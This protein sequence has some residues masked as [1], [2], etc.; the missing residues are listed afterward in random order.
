MSAPARRNPKLSTSELLAAQARLRE[1]KHYAEAVTNLQLCGYYP[2]DPEARSL[3]TATAKKWDAREE[4]RKLERE[5]QR[6]DRFTGPRLHTG[7][8]A[9]LPAVDFGAEAQDQVEEARTRLDLD[10]ASAIKMPYTSLDQAVGHGLLP[11]QFWVL[12]GDSGQ[13]KTTVVMSMA[14]LWLRAN[15]RLFIL[16]LEQ[17]ADT[18]RLYLAALATGYPVRSVLKNDW[19]ALPPLAKGEIEANLLW[20][21]DAGAPLLHLVREGRPT[22]R[23]IPQLYRRAADFGAEA[24]IIDHIHR[25]PTRDHNEYADLCATIVE[26]AKTYKIPALATAQNHRGTGPGAGDRLKAHLLPYVDRIQGGKVLEQ[27]ASVILGAYRPLKDGL[28][29]QTL[30]ELRRGQ[31]SV[32]DYLKPNVVAIAGLKARIEGNAGWVVDLTWERG[33][34]VDPDDERAQRLEERYGV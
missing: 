2:D 24:F 15:R 7:D 8:E 16:P 10:F 34:I 3:Y 14:E 6:L 26:M 27:E 4:L 17:G 9:P 29:D 33:R 20:Q 13:G 28:D 11:E 19:S 23:Q 18:T 30:A 31:L 5:W 22:V 1:P 21:E 32:R 25:I 12:A